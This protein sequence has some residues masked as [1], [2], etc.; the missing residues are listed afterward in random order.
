[1]LILR[2]LKLLALR[3][4]SP[5]E[6]LAKAGALMPQPSAFIKNTHINIGTGKDLTINDLAILIKKIV[7]FGGQIDWDKSKP[8]GTY[9][10]MLDVSKI[11]QLGWKE[12]ISLH[13]G[14]E[15]LYNEFYI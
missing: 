9:R 2:I 11:N 12:R 6:A 5:A 13:K 15:M 8:D 4:A 10:K 14:L 1:M 3:P 7:S